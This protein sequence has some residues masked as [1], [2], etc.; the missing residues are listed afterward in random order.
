MTM[1]GGLLR[2]VGAVVVVL[3]L[4]T[5]ASADQ[6]DFA[7]FDGSNPANQPNAGAVCA[8]NSAFTYHVVVAN[9]GSD[10]EI[11]ITYKDGDIVRFPIKAGAS[12]AFSQAAG[13]RGGA[14]KA[15]RVSNGGSPAQLAG[16]L[17]AVGQGKP[18]CVSCDAVS[19]G[20]VG[21]PACD[22][23]VPN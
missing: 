22:T 3:G 6:S 11:R 8:A 23:I 15:V 10:G 17:S 4:T 1:N 14:D 9:W 5:G 19:E 16:S 12:F 18:T 21:D 7:L 20:G 2:L 13:S